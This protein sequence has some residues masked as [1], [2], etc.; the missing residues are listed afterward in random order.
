MATPL[1]S[2]LSAVTELFVTAGVYWFIFQAMRHD[3]FHQGLITFALTYEVLVNIAYMTFRLLVP[4][5]GSDVSGGMAALYAFHGILSLVM[6]ISLVAFVVTALRLRRYG[7]NLFRARPVLTWSFM[8]LW[9]VSVLSGELIYV[10][11]YLV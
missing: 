8:V 1:F 4:A 10:L 9:A 2:T 6:F 3:R 5:E 11:T 7:H